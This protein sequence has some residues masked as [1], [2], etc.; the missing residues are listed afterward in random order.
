MALTPEYHLKAHRSSSS[1]ETS[2]CNNIACV[3]PARFVPISLCY[4]RAT[5]LLYV[6][7]G[8]KKISKVGDCRRYRVYG[9]LLHFYTTSEAYP[10]CKDLSIEPSVTLIYCS[11]ILEIGACLQPGSLRIH[12]RGLIF[13]GIDE[14]RSAPKPMANP[15]NSVGVAETARCI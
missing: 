13:M 12:I 7:I 11:L 4:I 5:A 3:I 14:P 15:S 1:L 6:V 2:S 9:S 8:R 10:E